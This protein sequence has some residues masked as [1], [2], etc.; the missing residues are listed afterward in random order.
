M[1]TRHG[2]PGSVDTGL[3]KLSTGWTAARDDRVISMGSKTIPDGTRS[4]LPGTEPMP[5]HTAVTQR[6]DAP[7]IAF[8]RQPTVSVSIPA[9]ARDLYDHS[10]ASTLRPVVA[11][12][13]QDV[14]TV[15]TVRPN[16]TSARS[17]P[18]GRG[19]FALC[20]L[21]LVLGVVA[22][23]LVREGDAYGAALSS[24]TAKLQ[25]SPKASVPR[26]ADVIAAR[27]TAGI[28]RGKDLSVATAKADA[29]VPVR[30]GK[31]SAPAV[32]APNPVD[33]LFIDFEPT[34]RAPK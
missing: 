18:K 27:A 8:D 15:T 17:A 2:C 31:G 4:A 24:A 7:T 20:T 32:T 28:A 1:V 14:P 9:K 12:S 34:F 30:R 16:A 29:R 19:M 33:A 26:S 22:G 13:F 5:S 3:C 25:G 23:H 21:C 11:R 10:T 6:L